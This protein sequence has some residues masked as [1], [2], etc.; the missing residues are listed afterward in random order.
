[1]AMQRL[2]LAFYTDF[3]DIPFFLIP[4]LEEGFRLSR[5]IINFRIW[6]IMKIVSLFHPD[7]ETDLPKVKLLIGVEQNLE[8]KVPKSQN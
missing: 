5:S 2:F 6:G 4:L 1:M 3:F 7:D 8:L